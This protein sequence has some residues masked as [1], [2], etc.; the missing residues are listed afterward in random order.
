M[1]LLTYTQSNELKYKAV[2][3]KSV[4]FGLLDKNTLTPL[5]PK[6]VP[7]FELAEIFLATSFRVE[8][9]GC[10]IISLYEPV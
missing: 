10:R 9:V 7:L 6:S 5:D 1:A 2:D 4:K 8:I 3:K